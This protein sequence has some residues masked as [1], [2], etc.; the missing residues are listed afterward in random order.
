MRWLYEGLLYRQE[1]EKG[2]PWQAVDTEESMWCLEDDLDESDE[3]VKT[4]M[5]SL[6]QPPLTEDE[7][8]WKKGEVSFQDKVVNTSWHRSPIRHVYT[9]LYYVHTRL[10][11]MSLPPLIWCK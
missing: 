4:L 11:R 6:V 9:F 3:N 5:I 10:L 7:I 1:L 8:T 2:K